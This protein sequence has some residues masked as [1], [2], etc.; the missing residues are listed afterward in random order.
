MMRRGARRLT[1]AAR[2]ATSW[3]TDAQHR[4]VQRTRRGREKGAQAG[5]EKEGEREVTGWLK[6]GRVTGRSRKRREEG[7]REVCASVPSQRKRGRG[8]KRGCEATGQ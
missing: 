4:S 6:A 5:V 7:M 3:E 8:L 2:S 1:S